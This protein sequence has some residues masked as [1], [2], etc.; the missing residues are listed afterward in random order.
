METAKPDT[1]ESL[2]TAEEPKKQTEPVDDNLIKVSESALYRKYFKMLKFGIQIA[3]VKQK[4]ASEGLEASLL[5]N[6]DLMIEK[7]E[8][9]FEEQ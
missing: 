5:D 6:P 7:T 3:A 2:S 8:E 4:M 9:D 1:P